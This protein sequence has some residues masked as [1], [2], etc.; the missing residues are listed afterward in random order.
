MSWEKERNR[1]TAEDISE[2]EQW[3]MK[4]ASKVD[5]FA[6]KHFICNY[7]WQ[8]EDEREKDRPT[9]RPTDIYTMRFVPSAEEK[10]RFL[11]QR[12]WRA[13][14]AFT[15]IT[16]CPKNGLNISFISFVYDDDDD[17]REQNRRERREC[18]LDFYISCM[19]FFCVCLLP[20][21]VS[22]L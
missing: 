13:L 18:F 4:K 14:S 19:F 12:K 3:E 22:M 6:M 15:S 7:R 20:K 10:L 11:V 16:D 5:V 9:K 21:W 1:R 8:K 17:Y 2:Q